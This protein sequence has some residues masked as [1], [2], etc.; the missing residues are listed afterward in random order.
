MKAKIIFTA[1]LAGAALAGGCSKDFVET[2]PEPT[3]KGVVLIGDPV[4]FN[5]TAKASRAAVNDRGGVT[6]T[7]GDTFAIVGYADD[8][9]EPYARMSY[10]LNDDSAGKSA[11]LFEGKLQ[12]TDADTHRFEAY[13]P[14][15]EDGMG[16][17]PHEF[18]FDCNQ[19][20]FDISGHDFLMGSVVAESVESE[21]TMSVNRMTSLMQFTINN[22]TGNEVVLTNV[23]FSAAQGVL[24]GTFKPV[25]GASSEDNHLDFSAPA[26]SISA[27]VT[28]GQIVAGGQAIVRMIVN[29]TDLT[30]TNVAVKL[31]FSDGNVYTTSFP[32]RN[33]E[34]SGNYNKTLTVDALA[35]PNDVW[36]TKFYN[37]EYYEF[38]ALLDGS[39][40]SSSM[41][42]SIRNGGVFCI[43]ADDPLTVIDVSTNEDNTLTNLTPSGTNSSNITLI[44]RYV[45]TPV[46]FAI[47]SFA[48]G[49]VDIENIT[50]KNLTVKALTDNYALIRYTAASTAIV[51]NFVLEDCTL[52]NFTS[53]GVTSM[54]SSATTGSIKNITVNNCRILNCNSTNGTIRLSANTVHTGRIESVT[55]TNNTFW[56]PTTATGTANKVINIAG[57]NTAEYV[58]NATININNNTFCN[59]I[60]N[61]ITHSG[62]GATS[63]ASFNLNNNLFYHSGTA[64]NVRFFNSATVNTY[65]SSSLADNY[66]NDGS[67]DTNYTRGGVAATFTLTTESPVDTEK[68]SDLDLKPTGNTVPA[69]VGDPRWWK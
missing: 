24:A 56:L 7:L 34:R 8:A 12:F 30:G 65:G 44:G 51:N 46:T 31:T 42:S 49:T 25:W 39:K 52:L 14:Y 9:T 68:Y 11:G 10:R 2:T 62:A 61:N 32:G 47:Q 19:T 64:T 20:V 21:V 27:D 67:W 13:H 36:T 41:R 29:A 60:G 66:Y 33:M 50:V 1:I 48:M 18:T 40:T 17:I 63:A 54:N 43:G 57:S 5:I 59:Y 38:D 53:G 37:G 23:T 15:S 22:A 3:D 58:I 28:N 69:T 55:I 26:R 45:D 4:S 6:W 16:R 35:D